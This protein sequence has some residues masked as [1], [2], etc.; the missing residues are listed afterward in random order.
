MPRAQQGIAERIPSGAD[1]LLPQRMC[2]CLRGVE[3]HREFAWRE[4]SGHGR[5]LSF[6]KLNLG[7]RPRA[8]NSA[9]RESILQIA[10]KR[11]R[12]APRHP[13]PTIAG[14]TR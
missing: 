3:L 11:P 13:G 12:K 10:Q 7:P 1:G 8:G 14:W 6:G 5:L 2:T 4:S 9:S